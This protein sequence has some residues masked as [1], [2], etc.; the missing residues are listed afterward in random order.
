MVFSATSV[1][2]IMTAV[3][4]SM[5]VVA[6]PAVVSDL[7][8]TAAQAN[9]IL[10]SYMLVTTVL[11]L[12]FGRLSDLLGR[13]RIYLAGLIVLTLSS[14]ACALAGN[15]ELLIA[16]RIAQAI[17]AAAVI[18]NSTALLIDHF[19]SRSLSLGLGYNVAVAS[20]ANV[21]GPVL[22]GVLVA[23]LDWRAV[24]GV[25]VPIGILGIAWAWLAVPKDEIRMTARHFNIVSTSLLLVSLTTLLLF[26]TEGSTRGWAE[27]ATLIYVAVSLASGATFL[28][29]QFNARYPLIDMLV[30]RHRARALAYAANFFMS[31]G[32]FVV[33][34]LASLYIQAALGGTALDAGL[35]I[36][37]LAAG[38][39]VGSPLSGWLARS[40]SARTISS[41]GCLACAVGIGVL[42]WASLP[43]AP[44]LM[45]L[46]LVL[47]GLGNGLF[48][49]PNT[50]ELMASVPSNLRGVANGLRSMLQNSGQAVSTAV[51]LAI[52]TTGLSSVAKVAV[53]DGSLTLLSA[54][55]VD[56]FVHG[57]HAALV[58]LLVLALLA[59]VLSLLR[60]SGKPGSASVITISAE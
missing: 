17:G 35:A 50:T 44:P 22:G 54:G 39:M 9:W 49:T 23:V 36:F 16:F 18:T 27:S 60:A 25:I 3:N 55:D 34:V 46:G 53:Y 6:L 52:V 10:L 59:G 11:I 48:M 26:I 47:A 58:V 45:Q 56:I 32:R 24:F 13:R 29:I 43:D 30:L 40:Y 20:A 12:S 33:V 15:V 4:A 42:I 28:V 51:A 41:S 14:L 5:L 7:G 57:Y 21:L 1:G 2:L 8:A 19:P 38:L 31:T 37:P